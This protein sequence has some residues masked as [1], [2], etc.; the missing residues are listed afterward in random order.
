MFD[1]E[2][3]QQALREF[4]LDGWLLYDF[5][6]Q[7]RAGPPRTRSR[8]GTRRQPPLGLLPACRWPTQET[9]APHR[10]RALDAIPGQ[11]RVYLAW[12]EFEGPG[13]AWL[14]EG[15]DTVATEY[16]PRAGNPYVSESTPARSN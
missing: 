6:Q 8:R 7:Q 2:P 10:G 15:L 13:L 5:P 11:S 3:I 14:L 4:A 12:Q 16:A 9:G 1:P